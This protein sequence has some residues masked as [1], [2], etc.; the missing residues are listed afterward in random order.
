MRC[1]PFV[2]RFVAAGQP[3]EHAIEAY[4][5]INGGGSIE[6]TKIGG[7]RSGARFISVDRLFDRGAAH[8]A[9]GSA[10]V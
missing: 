4:K 10:L 3:D 8:T 9:K 1:D 6:F 2:P 5:P 7:Q